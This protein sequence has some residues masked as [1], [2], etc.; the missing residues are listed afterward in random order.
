MARIIEG[1]NTTKNDFSSGLYLREIRHKSKE[2][3]VKWNKLCNGELL[4]CTLHQ[5][6]PC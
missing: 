4:I 2:I 3:T 5:M 1:C 6:L